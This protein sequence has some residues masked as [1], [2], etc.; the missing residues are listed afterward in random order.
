MKIALITLLFSLH[1]MLIPNVQDFNVN[2][3]L[4]DEQERVIQLCPT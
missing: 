3:T 1:L 4:I 2:E